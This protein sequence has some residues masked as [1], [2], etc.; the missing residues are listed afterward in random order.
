MISERKAGNADLSKW[1]DI[2]SLIYGAKKGQCLLHVIFLTPPKLHSHSTILYFLK[3]LQ[4]NSITRNTR[5][6]STQQYQ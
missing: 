6:E 2:A 4:A 1:L 5:I 3:A